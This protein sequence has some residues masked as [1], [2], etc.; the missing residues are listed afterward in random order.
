MEL[1]Q[2]DEIPAGKVSNNLEVLI[3]PHLNIR[4]YFSYLTP[5]GGDS[6]KYDG[7]SIPGNQRE[8]SEWAP[9]KNLG[10]DSSN[11]LVNYLGYSKEKYLS[12]LEYEV[13]S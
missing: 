4:N 3:D 10:E 9:M 1:L 7:Q 13:I 2:K 12:L 8:R 11:I 6:E 5:N